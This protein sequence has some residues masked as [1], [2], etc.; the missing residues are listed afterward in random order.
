MPGQVAPAGGL[1]QHGGVL[2]LLG[3]FLLAAPPKGERM[4][5]P[6]LRV[7]DGVDDGARAA[8]EDALLTAARARNPAVVGS[9][10]LAALLD[11]EAA[12]QS[13]GCDGS[14]CDAEIADALGAPELLSAQL[15]RAG[16]STWVLSLKRLRRVDMQVVASHQVIREGE[17][18]VVLTGAIDEL[19]DVVIGPRSGRPLLLAGAGVAGVGA[20]VGAVGGLMLWLGV[21]R[22]E[23]GRD[24]LD[25]GDLQK[26]F[27][28]RR[29]NE[30]L[31]PTGGVLALIGGAV[32]VGGAAVVV[33]DL[34][35]GEEP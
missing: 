33:V 23:E 25:D 16:G 26:A 2:P 14:G 27:E 1:V 11:A 6:P 17:S 24:A 4:F 3:L 9:A 30:W 10:D 8:V 18:P 12:K 31:T 13:V 19:A 28:I 7:S 32:V 22:F 5:L 15:L 34:L 21:V 20:V 29:D 35:R